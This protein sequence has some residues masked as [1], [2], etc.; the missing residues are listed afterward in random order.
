MSDFGWPRRGFLSFVGLEH[1][2]SAD[3]RERPVR[4]AEAGID[5]R[6]GGAVAVTTDATL[7]GKDGV[8]HIKTTYW[9]MLPSGEQL[10]QDLFDIELE[11]GE[12]N[13]LASDNQTVVKTPMMV[14][15]AV[16]VLGRKV[17]NAADEG[18]HGEYHEGRSS[19]QGLMH[20]LSRVLGA[21]GEV[22][23]Q[24]RD[25]RLPEVA[26]IFKEYAVQ[27]A[28]P[29]RLV[30]NGLS[31]NGG[32]DFDPADT[33]GTKTTGPLTVPSAIAPA[34][35]GYGVNTL[36][37]HQRLWPEMQKQAVDPRTGTVFTTEA[38]V[39]E[40]DN[41][42]VSTKI[43][44]TSVFGS[45]PAQ[46]IPCLT[47]VA[48][49]NEGEGRST[50]AK[51]NLIGENL[52]ND[53]QLMRMRALGVTNRILHDLRNRRYPSSMDH[54]VE[55]DLYDMVYQFE[56]PPPL[57][58]GGRLMMMSLGGNNMEE[59]AEGFGETIGGN[60]KVIY[61][62]GLDKENKLDRVGIIIDLGLYLSPKDEANV[63]AAPDVIE[64]LKHCKDIL[65][66][67]RHLDHTDGLFVYIQAG[68]LRG[69]TVHATPEVIRSIR[70]KL[71]TFPSIDKHNYPTFSELEGEGWLHIKDKEGKTRLSVN[72]ARNATPH[73]AR[74]TPFCVHGHYDGKWIGSYLNHGD[75]RYGRHNVR[76]YKGPPVDVDPLNREFFT[77]STARLLEEVP[78]LDPKIAGR[79]PTY[80][81]IDITSI[82]KKGWAPTEAEVEENL[83]E[84]SD[85]FKD[86]GMLLS[87]IS[88]NDNRFETALRVATRADRDIT[89]FGTNLEKTSVT[90]NVLG[91][92]DLR[93]DP[94]PRNNI[95]L[96]LDQCFE[97]RIR[98]KIKEFE[99][100]LE[101][102][103]ESGKRRI[104]GRIELQNERLK[105][106]ERL[107]AM[108]HK[109]IR[110]QTRDQLEA[111]L[112]DRFGEKVT[113]GSVRVGRTSKTSRWIMN[114]PN[115]DWRRLALLTGTQG[116]NVEID[117]A[118]SALADGR[119]LMDGN[120][121]HR[122]TARPVVPENNVVVISQTA[123]PGNHE[124]Q[125][126]LV[127]KLI[128]RG[129]TVVQARDDGFQIHNIDKARRKEI[130]KRLVKLD[131]EFKVE[132]DGSLL[133]LGMPIHAGGHGH[134]KDC[135]AWI[136]MVKADV[137]AAQHTS[138]PQGV[139]RFGELCRA[140]GCRDMGWVPNF[141]GLSIRAGDTPESTV[142]RE[143]GQTMPSLI[144]IET[145]RKT[146][147]YH[148]GYMDARRYRR[149]DATEGN[150]G[151]YGLRVTTRADGIYETSFASVDAEERAKI[152]AAHHPGPP[153]PVPENRMPPPE[154]R[155]D[156]GP[157]LPGQ[158]HRHR[159]FRQQ[160]Q[161]QSAA[162]A[163]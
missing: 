122:H 96:Y 52:V 159:F 53:N 138:D 33:S 135:Q 70:N 36:D 95:Q 163:R 97:E 111:E 152:L 20:N 8:R 105:A 102:A 15:R 30:I 65:I 68:L 69:K 117:A 145:K 25:G 10:A 56:P 61:H 22:N 18:E 16:W 134:Q 63:S 32:F 64:H 156:R 23:R 142:V 120:P 39:A 5:P 73:S 67:H 104:R 153:E 85:W 155:L 24:L 125:D 29:D 121:D 49:K 9:R 82:L 128:T 76:G 83:V 143:I 47:R 86:K 45:K 80:F 7:D 154:E 77:N 51:L 66:T 12:S 149:L 21:A 140:A 108:P 84:V 62:E 132:E 109:F 60:S 136:K 78:G 4:L 58:E 115:H 74:C 103:G 88:T 116:T 157:I 17:Y 133:V 141:V 123:I 50:L 13:V 28:T 89:E 14:P 19:A 126:E 160:G 151:L 106:F 100:E 161:Q 6:T 158:E 118:L 94:E 148:G 98:K 71:S 137:T 127:R 131:K 1:S 59:I 124:K 87:M 11:P 119:S 37:E 35:M 44:P 150:Y 129:F 41:P 57:A 107:K 40:G 26:K 55:Y 54:L 72:Y 3:G 146:R 91:V 92:N 48:W 79:A 99:E 46:P 114:R 144:H 75:A 34:L 101:T 2:H 139:K 31:P 130:T 42:E 112:E 162:F 90:A 93:L 110:Y 43:A 38:S 27:D 81:D 147:Q 113:L